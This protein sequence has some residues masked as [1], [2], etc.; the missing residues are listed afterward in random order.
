VLLLLRARQH[1]PEEARDQARDH[2]HGDAGDEH[3]P[4]PW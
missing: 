2:D 1:Y 4:V 3:G